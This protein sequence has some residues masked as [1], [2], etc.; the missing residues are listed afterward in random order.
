MYCFLSYFFVI[1]MVLISVAFITLLERKILGYVHIR[2]G[3]NKVG[4]IGLFQPFSDAIKLFLKEISFLE[5]Y[6]IYPFLFS[7][8]FGMFLALFLWTLFPSNF[9]FIDMN[10]GVLFFLC[11]SSMGV[12][13]ILMAGWASNSKYAL[14]GAYRG[15]AQTISYEVSFALV[16]LSLLFFI[17]SFCFDKIFT[18]QKNMWFIVMFFPLFLIWFSSC[19]AETNRTPFDLTEGESEL[20]SGFNVEYMSSGFAMIFMAE[21]ANII[22]MSM[23]TSLLFI[24]KEIL[25]FWILFFSVVFIWVRGTFPRFRYDKLMYMAWKCYLPL[26]LNFLFVSVSLKSLLL[27][28]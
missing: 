8:I 15:V 28:F 3:P 7:P 23:I 17:S 22:L 11:L 2:K 6:N 14:L 21:Y 12:Y 5:S 18:F 16:V 1:L 24:G 20:V 25:V 10:Y 19:L 9:V 13:S 4:V 26:A 27:F